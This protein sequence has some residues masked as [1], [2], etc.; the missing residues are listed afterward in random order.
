MV[1]SRIQRPLLPPFWLPVMTGLPLGL[2]LLVMALPILGHGNA[3]LSR[4]L[5]L[6]AFVL[7][8]LPLTALQ[9]WL[10][11]RGTP[12]WHTALLLLATT[13]VMA[14]AT[15]LLIIA[16]QATETG[17]LPRIFAPG[18]MDIS[19]LFRG[20]EGAWL[21][22]VAYCAVHAMV[23]YY[24]ALRQ[25][26]ADHSEARMLARDAELRALRYQLQPHFLFNTLNAVSALVADE[27]SAEAR[28][29]LARLSD[30]LRTVLE[31]RPH[32]EVTL[33]EEI[34]MTEA[35]LEVEKVRLG[36][37]LQL[38]WQIGEGVLGAH[39]PYLLLQ[40]LVENAIRHGIAPRREP[41]Q[42]DV[43]VV[44]ADAHLD[45]RIRNDL[46]EAVNASPRSHDSREAVGLQNVRG[47]LAQLYAGDATLHTGMQ[48]HR[49]H[50]HLTVPLRMHAEAAA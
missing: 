4:T 28:Q 34:A 14:L 12:A 7:W 40:P 27:R 50:V 11:R 41:G 31:A 35:Y 48:D 24:A 1:T 9:R 13:Y 18:T 45:I 5:Y 26:Q 36:R 25:E 47:R 10:W 39:V 49:Y 15:R 3:T 8:L 22:L 42:L 38:T 23:I 19:L 17:S 33:A 6:S 30:F 2:C 20:L 16:I 44:R 37:R 43:H 21:V 32:H 46:P 29:M